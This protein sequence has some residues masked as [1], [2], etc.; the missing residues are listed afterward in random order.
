MS[1]LQTYSEATYKC[2]T[3]RHRGLKV[4]VLTLAKMYEMLNLL[5]TKLSFRCLSSSAYI[6]P[7]IK[8]L[9]LR[10][11]QFR[12]A[13]VNIKLIYRLTLNACIFPCLSTR[14]NY[15]LFE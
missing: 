6:M 2:Y 15:Y 8:R 11:I 1:L 14:L 5:I 3:K 9:I 4:L 10:K 13:G 7:V 12:N